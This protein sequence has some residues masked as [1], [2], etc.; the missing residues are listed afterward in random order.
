MYFSKKLVFTSF[1]YRVFLEK[2]V[3]FIKGVPRRG[4]APLINRF[5]EKKITRSSVERST[6]RAWAF[7]AGSPASGAGLIPVRGKNFLFFS[8]LLINFSDRALN[9]AHFFKDLSFIWNFFIRIRK[10]WCFEHSTLEAPSHTDR[11]RLIGTG[12][13]IFFPFSRLRLNFNDRKS[14]SRNY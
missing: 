11:V 13:V 5:S 6:I 7:H 1:I 12:K 9:L 2:Y 14:F 8:R 10:R 4:A 3:T